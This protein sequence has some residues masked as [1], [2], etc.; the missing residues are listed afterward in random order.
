MTP[1]EGKQASYLFD[2]D[3][4]HL[5]VRI[6]P[7]GSKSFVYA[8]K[9]NRAAIRITIGSVDT[10]NLDDA[11][12]EA[13][14]LQT[15]VDAGEDPRIV[16]AEKLAETAK[17]QAAARRADKPSLDIWSEYIEA[18]RTSWGEKHLADHFKVSKEGGEARTRGQRPGESKK[19]LPGILRPLLLLPLSEITPDRVKDWLKDESTKRPTHARL[20]FAILRAFLN[21]CGDQSAYRDFVHTDACAAR[22]A[23]GTLPKKTAKSDCMQKE[24][25]AP[26]FAEVKK[27]SPVQSA[28]LQCVLLVG[29]RRNELTGLRWKDVDFKWRSLTLRDKDESKGG[30]EGT[31]T[32][33]LTPYVASLLLDLKRRNDTPPPSHRILNGKKIA[34][35]L[36]SW[37]PSEFVFFGRAASGHIEEPSAAHERALKA[38]GLPHLSIH[39]LR[40]SFGTLTEWVECPAGVV[41]QLQG[42][43]PS[44]TAERHYR[45]RPLD[46][47]RLWH[48]KIEAWILEQAG[49]EQPGAGDTKE[50]VRVVS[51]A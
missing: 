45:V 18:R 50:A 29:A 41:A 5:A 19:T 34:N 13:R 14:R 6:T 1:P 8:G 10:W 38:A 48:T 16:K 33:P 7:S 12:A 25:L 2:D 44:A 40:R 37:K 9:L 49:I 21:W 22:V 20:A 46:L 42:H 30:V 17:K 26:W 36:E 32:I 11:R 23:K 4:K 51:S 28:Y 43:K 27:L 3:P 24:Q 35:N 39:G 47:L 15:I 31:R